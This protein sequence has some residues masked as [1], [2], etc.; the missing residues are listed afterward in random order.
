[1]KV[2]QELISVATRSRALISIS[3]QVAE[4]V[5]RSGVVTGLCTVFIRHTSASLLIT[6]NA[7]PAVRRDL[8]RWLSD[9]A[10]ES[11]EW[12]HDDEG[13]DDMP[14]HAK[15]ALTKTSESI[16]I[17]SSRLVLGTWQGIFIW[18]HR[19]LS[20]QRGIVVHVAG[21]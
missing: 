9:L 1:M 17:S 2:H 16:P 18:E 13:P 11:R 10:P 19:A 3:S 4:V 12:E 20:H 8:E 7:D 21:L 6:E 15:C 5:L 14:A